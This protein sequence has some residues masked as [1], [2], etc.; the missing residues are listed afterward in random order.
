MGIVD[1]K[2]VWCGAERLLGRAGV[3]V[4]ASVAPTADALASDAKSLVFVA[5]DRQ[6]IGVIA[7]A[8][9]LRPEVPGALDDLR[10]LGIRHLLLLTGDRRAVAAAVARQLGLE[11]EAEVLPQ[12]KIRAIE[13][14]QRAGR[15]VAMVGDG[16]NDA[17]ALAQADVGIAMGVAGSDA[18]IEAAH[19]ALMG[20][21]WRTVPEAV[22]TG[23]R[24]FRTIQQ[25][26]WFTA[27]YNIVGMTLAAIGILPPVLAAAAQAL[28]DVAVMVNSS[29]LLGR[30][31]AVDR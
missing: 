19:V 30:M 13:R 8:D 27:G 28:P 26:L 6:L 2:T 7:L 14:L 12:D 29:R 4:P 25:N 21:D 22:R 17:P 16:I 3:T 10:V 1:G 24:A 20:D 11:F 15:V 5:E 18:A 9:V 23:R 31:T